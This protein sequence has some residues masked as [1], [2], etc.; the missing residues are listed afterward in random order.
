SF[1]APN[2]PARVINHPVNVSGTE[3]SAIADA[4]QLG[5]HSDRILRELGYSPTEIVA[6]RDS[7]VV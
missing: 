7:G 5:E 3:R 2:G 6:F 4:P 1:S